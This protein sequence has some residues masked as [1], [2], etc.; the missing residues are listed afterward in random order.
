VLLSLPSTVPRDP[1][2]QNGYTHAYNSA[3]GCSNRHAGRGGSTQLG[4][5]ALSASSAYV[6]R[7]G[8]AAGDAEI[9]A[10]KR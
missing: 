7:L 8:P 10:I 3:S 5:T 2:Y 4:S 9:V 1:G 6:T